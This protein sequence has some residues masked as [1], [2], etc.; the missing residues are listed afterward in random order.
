V[1]LTGQI[2][3]RDGGSYKYLTI[4]CLSDTKKS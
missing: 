3:A 2:A 4:N 1:F